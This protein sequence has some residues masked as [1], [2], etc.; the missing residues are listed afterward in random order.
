VAAAARLVE[1]NLGE[2]TIPASSASGR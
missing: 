2:R 1:L